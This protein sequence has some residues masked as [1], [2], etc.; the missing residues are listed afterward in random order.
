[1][2]GARRRVAMLLSGGVDS[3][4]ALALMR[5]AGHE[6]TAFYLKIW[7]EEE[8]AFLGDCPWEEDMAYATE[9]CR[10]LEVP[11]EVVPLQDEYRQAVVEYALTA[12]R[13]GHT[14]SPDVLCNRAIKFGAFGDRLAADYDAVASG[15]YARLRRLP[16][17]R[18][19]LL[20][21]VD[22]V[23]DQ[24][25][26]LAYL[27][28]EQLGRLCFPIGGLHKR[29]VRAQASERDLAPCARRDSQGI[30]F[31]GKLSYRDFV[32]AHLGEQPGPIREAGTGAEL[33]SHRGHW[34]HTIGQRQGLGLGNGPWYVVAKEVA[35]NTVYVAHDAAAAA[36]D[37]VVLAD[38]NWIEPLP[39]AAL[40]DQPVLVRI[41]HGDAPRPATL[42]RVSANGGAAPA[43]GGDDAPVLRFDGP[44]PG[45]ASGQFAVLYSAAEPALCYGSAVMQRPSSVPSV[46]R[47]DGEEPAV[48]GT[49]A[50]GQA[51]AHPAPALESADL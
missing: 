7:L 43:D 48:P 5:E 35:A 34:F 49:F 2:S 37:S 41:R 16:D 29:E 15:H 1:M 38:G 27:R 42:S 8:L 14:P 3:A 22:P 26:F 24:S 36:P 25:Y 18:C 39:D 11:L 47:R 21:G 28:A 12:L 32:R 30:C 10:Q 6:L 19:Q 51:V 13:A 17:G 4:L 9:V 23:K 46:E 40:H 45:L 31:L 44:V 20:R 50:D 33:G